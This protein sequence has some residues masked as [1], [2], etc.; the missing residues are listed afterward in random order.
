ENTYEKG[1][2]GIWRIGSLHLYV[3]FVA[4]YEKGWA[5][6]KPGEGLAR[7]DASRAY[8]P[9]RGPTATYQPLPA[10]QMPAFQAPHPVT[11]E[12]VGGGQWCARLSFRRWRRL[13]GF[14]PRLPQPNVR[15]RGFRNFVSGWSVSKTRRRS[16]T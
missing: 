5:R 6:L 10:V 4:P 14:P 8:P 1:A 12:R 15:S 13:S 2:D 16:K 7:S 11:G 9:D 3:N